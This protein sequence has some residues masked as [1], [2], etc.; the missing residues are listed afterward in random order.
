MI[1]VKQ[2]FSYMAFL[3]FMLAMLLTPSM[4]L[5]VHEE[6]IQNLEQ[7]SLR[8]EDLIKELLD[9]I[10]KLE[11]KLVEKEEIK[12]EEITKIEEVKK[13]EKRVDLG[14]FL[15]FRYHVSNFTN[16]AN[17][18]DFQTLPP[19]KS[20]KGAD[21]TANYF[22]QR[23]QLYIMPKFGQ[24][25]S[26]MLAFN[27]DWRLGDSA[28]GVGQNAGGG[29]NAD[30]TN[31]ETKNAYINVNFPGTNLSGVFGLQ[32]IKD[33]YNGI[34]LGWANA[35]GITL[36]YKATDNLNT[37]LGLYR[38][39]QPTAR[40]KQS[41]ATDFIRGEVAYSPNK[42][43]N[44]G[45]NLYALL[46][47]TGA[48]S[49]ASDPGVLGGPQYGSTSNGYAPLSYNASTGHESL[50]GNTD[51]TMNLYLPGINFEYKAG[52]Y[53]FDG[54]FI[55]ETGKFGS[56]TASIEDVTINSYAANLGASTK[57]GPVNLKLNGLYV[58]GDNSN[59]NPSIGIKEHGFYTPGAYSLAAA[60]M[61]LTGMKIMFQDIDGTN[62]D[63]YLVYDVSN[64]LEQKPLGVAAAMITGNTS[65]SEKLTLE[66]G[67]GMLRSAKKRIVN[68]ESYMATEV[69][70]GLHY[71]VTKALSMGLVGA[72]AWVGDFYKVTDEQAVEYNANTTGNHI[73]ANKEPA[74]IWRMYFRTNYSF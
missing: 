32:T 19:D 3:I 8:Q 23:T 2:M 42:N 31:L 65:L 21:N 11:G 57:V 34:L 4:V 68:N 26:G 10:K 5:A 61:G 58:S 28:Y 40:L 74:D 70:L 59:K 41:V 56:G 20:V 44:L 16:Y 55:Y 50:V 60:W 33:P 49:T 24:Y 72:Y 45:F 27:L 67:L 25:V 69:N 29:L 62:Q 53:T 71:A 22:E 73:T 13:E 1:K 52:N 15:R 12:K 63:Q 9:R 17:N 46:D 7:K 35:G 18:F 36:N 37:I 38:F 43:L 54:F 64:I 66:G 48:G 51:Y 6:D 47:R 30:Q 14:G 39:W